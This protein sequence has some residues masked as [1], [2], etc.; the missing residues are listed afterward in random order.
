MGKKQWTVSYVSTMRTFHSCPLCRLACRAAT[1]VPHSC[2]FWASFWMVPRCDGGSCVSFPQFDARC[3]WVTIV[4]AS[5][6]V[7]SEGLCGGC[8]LALFSSHVRSNSMTFASWWCTCCLGCS[9]RDVAWRWSRA[10]IFAGFFYGSWRG[11]W[12]VCWG[13]LQLS[14]SILNRHSRVENMQLWYSL[15]LVLVLCWDDLHTFGILKGFLAL[16]RRFLVCHCLP[17]SCQT[18]LPR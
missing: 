17:T 16:L 15:C 6:L 4:S 7:S 18:V 14:S 12:K 13:R 5:L 1:K 8:C 2:L 11:R 9:G 3:S 10:R